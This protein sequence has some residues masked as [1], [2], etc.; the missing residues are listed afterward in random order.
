[1]TVSNLGAFNV[2]SFIPIINPPEAAVLGVGRVMPTPVAKDNGWIGV[3]PRCMLTLSVDHRVV[4]IGKPETPIDFESIDKRP[5]N[6]IVLLASPPDQTGPEG[7]RASEGTGTQP[8]VNRTRLTHRLLATRAPRP[9]SGRPEP[10][11]R[12]AK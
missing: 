9:C 6:L 10:R 3:E 2:E 5:V 4:A 7:T 12:A 1:M 11:R 8:T